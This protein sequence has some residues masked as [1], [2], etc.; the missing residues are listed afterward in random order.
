MFR[1]K[2][3]NFFW[4]GDGGFNSSDYPRSLIYRD[5][6]AMFPTGK[7]KIQPAS[8]NNISPVLLFEKII[9]PLK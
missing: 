3:Y 2:N 5:Y 6:R 7:Q 9:L 4:V 1:A 8:H